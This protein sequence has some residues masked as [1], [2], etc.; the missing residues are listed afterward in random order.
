MKILFISF[1]D[2][3]AHGRDIRSVSILRALA[4]AGHQVHVIAPASDIADHPNIKNLPTTPHRRPRWRLKVAVIKTAG[5]INFDIIHAVD[6]AVIFASK[7]C[8]LQKIR[9]VYDARRCFTGSVAREPFRHWK[10]FPAYYKKREKK[11]LGKAERVITTCSALSAD[12]S[13]LCPSAEIVSVEDVPL[14]SNI[15]PENFDRSKVFG[16]FKGKVSAVF[17]CSLGSQNQQEIRKVLMAARKVIDS[18]PGAVFFFKGNF[19]ADAEVMATNLDIFNRSAF[20]S[21]ID[22]EGFLSA[23][24]S[25]DVSLF[26]PAPGTRYIQSDIYTLLN[27][28]APVVAVEAESC[29]NLLSE[30]NSISVLSSSESMAEGL[31]QAIQEP[32]FSISLAAEGR[33][34]ITQ[35]YSLSSFKHKIRMAYIE[36]LTRE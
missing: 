30:R 12:L 29:K 19:P 6:D 26:F 16:N 11:I 4:D 17:M 18:V 31:L 2:V 13:T 3:S 5:S 8:F 34:L 28:S 10:W 20:I 9:F 24:N 22:D 35:R 32:L 25:A 14:Q 7:V 23:L 33:K 27:A 15:Y 21:D 36:V 1:G